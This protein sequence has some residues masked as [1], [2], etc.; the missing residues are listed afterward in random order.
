MDMNEAMQRVQAAGWNGVVV[1]SVGANA[2]MGC[3]IT[4][5][6]MPDYD[7]NLWDYVPTASEALT[8]L[9]AKAER[10]PRK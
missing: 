6:C 2:Y 3:L 10:Q 7:T 8:A 5:T 9:V 4:D 1:W